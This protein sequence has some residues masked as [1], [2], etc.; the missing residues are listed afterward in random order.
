[1]R[2]FWEATETMEEAE[3]S[4]SAS[5]RIRGLRSRFLEGQ[6]SERKKSIAN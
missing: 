6:A 5:D 3:K 1:M 2:D 4:S